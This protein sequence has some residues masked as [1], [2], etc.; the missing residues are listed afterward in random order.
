MMRADK[1]KLRLGKKKR[2]KALGRLGE[3][4]YQTKWQVLEKVF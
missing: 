4:L 1:E 2:E 3:Y